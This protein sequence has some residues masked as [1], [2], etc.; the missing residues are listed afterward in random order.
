MVCGKAELAGYMHVNAIGY[1]LSNYGLC[2][3]KNTEACE[4]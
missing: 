2:L 4:N 1:E 3:S